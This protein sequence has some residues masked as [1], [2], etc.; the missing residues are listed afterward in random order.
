LDQI[1]DNTLSTE[2][3]KGEENVFKIKDNLQTYTSDE[4]TLKWQ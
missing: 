1:K 3:T 4:A 2:E